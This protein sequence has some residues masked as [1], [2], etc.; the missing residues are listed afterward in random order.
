MDS[1]NWGAEE[2]FWMKSGWVCG[3]NEVYHVNKRTGLIFSDYAGQAFFVSLI[4]KKYFSVNCSNGWV[5]L[6]VGVVVMLVLLWVKGSI[7]PSTGRGTNPL[8]ACPGRNSWKKWLPLNRERWTTFLS[9]LISNLFSMPSFCLHNLSPCPL[10]PQPKHYKTQVF[11]LSCI[12]TELTVH[13]TMVERHHCVYNRQHTKY[14][15]RQ[16]MQWQCSMSIDNAHTT[17]AVGMISMQQL[18]RYWWVHPTQDPTLCFEGN[19]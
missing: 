1:V 17:D 7:F 8:T 3:V 2:Q 18:P 6:E 11:W 14:S 15:H 9:L 12:P 16:H 19:W 10:V 13:N 4:K 5:F